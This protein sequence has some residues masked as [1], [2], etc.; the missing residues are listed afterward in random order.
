MNKEEWESLAG[1]SGWS[2][3]KQYL[4]DYRSAIAE[5]M[6]SGGL[7]GEHM[8][9]AIARCQILKDMAEISFT[10]IEE[11]YAKPE[12]EKYEPGET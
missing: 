9:D 7:R 8:T 2:A 3:L 10:D 1:N 6:A 5:K 4:T 11:F 12:E